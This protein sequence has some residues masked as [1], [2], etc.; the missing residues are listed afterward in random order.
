ME[1][2]I[3]RGPYSAILEVPLRLYILNTLSPLAVTELISYE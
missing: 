1:K 2:Q 3:F